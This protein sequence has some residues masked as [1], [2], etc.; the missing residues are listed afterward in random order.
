MAADFLPALVKGIDY[1]TPLSDDEGLRDAML[2]HAEDDP[3]G[4]A[5]LSA[6]RLVRLVRIAGPT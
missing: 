3:R 4:E 5:R 1:I 6:A 2:K